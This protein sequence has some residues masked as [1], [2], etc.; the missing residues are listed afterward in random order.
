[1]S[2]ATYQSADPGLRLGT[3]GWSYGGWVGNFYPTGTKPGDQ[4]PRY[5]E[6]LKVV[7]IDATF[8]HW[9]AAR[10]IVSWR[11]RTP[12][13]FLFCPK[14]NRAV[15]HD[16]SLENCS[17]ELEA[18]C[19]SMRLLGDKLG[20]IVLQ[21]PASFRPEHFPILEAF[22]PQL[23]GDLRFAVEVRSPKWL[24]PDPEPYLTLLRRHQ[25]AHVLSDVPRM[26]PRALVTAGFAYVRVIGDYN[27][28]ERMYKATGIDTHEAKFTHTLLDRAG[29]LNHWV[30][31]IRDLRAQ[32]VDVFTFFN[33]HFAGH[34][35]TTLTEFIQL[36]NAAGSPPPEES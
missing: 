13:G 26:S 4:L 8:H 10:T 22:L 1:M 25:V 5:A 16:K 29:D 15:T 2:D 36:Y 33:N 28:T 34:A 30:G 35:P 7:E 11:E 21:F 17:E 31:L 12:D 18:F 27:I 6:M 3:A 14:M 20:P 23:P 24:T 9:I 19:R 32:K